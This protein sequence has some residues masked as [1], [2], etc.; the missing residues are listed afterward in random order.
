[1][2][3]RM[4]WAF[5]LGLMLSAASV[6]QKPKLPYQQAGLTERQ[7]AAYL[8]DRLAYGPRPG[9]ID[10][11]VK[12]GLENWVE[13]QLQGA[14]PESPELT[15]RLQ[16]MPALALT[17]AELTQKY[18]PAPRVRNEAIQA[19]VI[20]KEDKGDTDKKAYR[21]KIIQFGMSKG[22]RPGRELVNQLV[23]QKILRAV[24]GNNQLSEV[25]T[26]FWFNH[27]N[28][29]LTDNQCRLQILSYE[30]DAIR[31]N[32]LGTFRGLL[33][34][35]AKHPAMLLYLDNAQ[36][37]AAMDARTSLDDKMDGLPP[38]AQAQAKQR[39]E[40]FKKR[41]KQ[42]GVNENYAR[43]LMELHTLGVDGGYTQKDVQPVAAATPD[44]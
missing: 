18:P 14:Q 39:A 13:Q 28:V 5:M 8:L 16:K 11:V 42:R 7:A 25:M 6:A 2:K 26:D 40:Q 27:F 29:S 37:T 9:E 1:M 38:K 43:E 15:A 19:G 20:S 44:N 21:Q 22:Y 24:Y 17:P 33:G 36:S 10:R 32:V 4:V 23:G 12:M 3:L 35:T 30:R 41:Q 34:A 31:P